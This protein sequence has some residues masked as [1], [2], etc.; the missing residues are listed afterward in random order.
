VNKA[1]ADNPDS[2]T[3]NVDDGLP[4]C[5]QLED[6]QDIIIDEFELDPEFKS[7]LV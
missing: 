4:T 6:W 7:R 3:D 5:E 2:F 1:I